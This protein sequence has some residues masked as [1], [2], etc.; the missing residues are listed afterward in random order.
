MATAPSHT[1]IAGLLRTYLR[2]YL[3]QVEHYVRED[4]DHEW[5]LRLGTARGEVEK[6]LKKAQL[7]TRVAML[8]EMTVV[9]DYSRRF[10]ES[11]TTRLLED[12]EREVV[13]TAYQAYLGT[14]PGCPPTGCSSR[15]TPRRWRTT[16]SSP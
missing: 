1:D 3:D 5:S 9:E 10:R 2:S 14:V 8:D 16:S 7:S 6:A 11:S 13:E 4:R 15:A 12:D